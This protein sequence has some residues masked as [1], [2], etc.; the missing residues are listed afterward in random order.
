MSNLLFHTLAKFALNILKQQ[1]YQCLFNS[2]SLF[3][4][5]LIIQHTINQRS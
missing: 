5:L 4:N 1:L 3:P 2:K